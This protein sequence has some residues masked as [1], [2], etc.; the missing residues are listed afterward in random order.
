M[1][2]LGYDE[3]WID[4]QD[5]LKND[6]ELLKKVKEILDWIVPVSKEDYFNEKDGI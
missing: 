3:N 2:L 6:I 1:T 5:E 4:K